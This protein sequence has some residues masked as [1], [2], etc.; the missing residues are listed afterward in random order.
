VDL[1][2]EEWARTRTR[3]LL[4]T[5]YLLTG[6]QHGAED[7]VQSALE[8]VLLAWGR[9]REDPDAYARTVLHRE[10]AGS[11]RKRR[12]IEVGSDVGDE[13]R[14]AD[15][16]GRVDDQLVLQSAL[17]RLARRQRAVIVLRFYEDRTEAEVAEILG[18]SIGTVKSQTHKALRTLRSAS[19]ELDDLIQRKQRSDV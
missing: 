8:K 7:L 6:T 4:R 1:P 15:H 11:W 2:F 13:P 14:S 17:A 10:H 3:P 5:A 9:I 12:L 19:P 18:C 16:A